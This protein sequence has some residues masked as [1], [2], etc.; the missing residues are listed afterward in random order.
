MHV[1][2]SLIL[3]SQPLPSPPLAFKLDLMSLS[4]KPAVS[5]GAGESE[6]E[7]RGSGRSTPHS[8]STLEDTE[9]ADGM[10]A[11]L[12]VVLSAIAYSS[13]SYSVRGHAAWDSEQQPGSLPE[14]ASVAIATHSH[15]T[16]SAHTDTVSNGKTPLQRPHQCLTHPTYHPSPPAHT[17]ST[18]SQL[19]AHLSG[20]S[21]EDYPPMDRWAG[22]TLEE[23]RGSEKVLPWQQWT[24][25][26]HEV[27]HLSQGSQPLYEEDHFVMLPPKAAHNS[28]GSDNSPHT[29]NSLQSTFEGSHSS[30]SS[31]LQHPPIA[32]GSSGYHSDGGLS[33]TSSMEELTIINTDAQKWSDKAGQSS[34]IVKP[35]ALSQE[36]VTQQYHT[37]EANHQVP[38]AYSLPWQHNHGVN[39]PTHQGVEDYLSQPWGGGGCDFYGYTLSQPA[40]VG[41]PQSQ[42]GLTFGG[43]RHHG[44]QSRDIKVG[45]PVCVWGGG[46]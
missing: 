37:H 16:T 39:H 19:M 33:T 12:I 29:L 34:A 21:S 28:Y 10:H 8:D 45:P 25:K 20:L 42:A 9:R 38:Q 17:T 35:L 24:A 31:M 46:G 22:S 7:G 18:A 32:S 26:F 27:D 4:P 1:C 40:G 13:I 44:G 14:L 11:L 41:Y 43:R 36:S 3:H 5:P 23:G 30:G 6:E 2:V 15:A